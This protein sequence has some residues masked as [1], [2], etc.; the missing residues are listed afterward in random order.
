MYRIS[1]SKKA[2]KFLHSLQEEEQRRVKQ[3]LDAMSIDPFALDV[4]K[5]VNKDMVTYR[6]RQGNYRI[7]FHIDSDVLTIDVIDIDHRK[8]VY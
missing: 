8:N 1:I 4:K 5:L 2:A 6:V 3:K 7:I